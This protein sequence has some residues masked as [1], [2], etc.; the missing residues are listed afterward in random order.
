[1]RWTV[2]TL[3][4]H[5]VWRSRTCP[6]RSWQWNFRSGQGLVL[7]IACW[8]QISCQDFRNWSSQVIS[9]S[10]S[11]QPRKNMDHTGNLAAYS[12]S[13]QTCF[14]CQATASAPSA[15]LGPR[16]HFFDRVLKRRE[17]QA[18]KTTYQH[19]W[20]WRASTCSSLCRE[21]FSETRI[22]TMTTPEN[23]TLTNKGV[24]RWATIVSYLVGRGEENFKSFHMFPISYENS[25]NSV[26]HVHL[27]YIFLFLSNESSPARIAGLTAQL[28]QVK[29]GSPLQQL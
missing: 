9:K 26:I 20:K 27:V 5:E 28:L 11:H 22:E 19:Q 29:W 10:L 1:M 16:G 3:D 7:F 25:E 4:P 8:I 2:D 21:T 24:A 14:F 18:L 15:C 13:K 12:G 17:R 23:Q 6:E